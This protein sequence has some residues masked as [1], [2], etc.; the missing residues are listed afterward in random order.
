MTKIWNIT[1][2]SSLSRKITILDMLIKT[3]VLDYSAQNLERWQYL[4]PISVLQGWSSIWWCEKITKR[5]LKS[6]IKLQK[7]CITS[8]SCTWK[9]LSFLLPF[10]TITT[11]K[12][13]LIIFRQ[14]YILNF[15]RQV[16]SLRKNGFRPFLSFPTLIQH[17]TYTLGTKFWVHLSQKRNLNWRKETNWREEKSQ[18]TK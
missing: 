8:H 4:N 15:V 18:F 7:N 11:C 17:R 2:Q 6:G 1:R 9:G 14:N 10:L 12:S 13:I 16:Q 5:N 3:W